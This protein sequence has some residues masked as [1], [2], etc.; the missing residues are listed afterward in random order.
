MSRFW[1]FLPFLALLCCASSADTG[2]ACH[3]GVCFPFD[4]SVYQLGEIEDNGYDYSFTLTERKHP[5]NAATFH[6]IL[7]PSFR[8]EAGI[9]GLDERMEEDLVGFYP[10]EDP[11][12]RFDGAFPFMGTHSYDPGYPDACGRYISYSGFRGEGKVYGRAAMCFVRD[13]YTRMYTECSNEASADAFLQLF[14]D[15]WYPEEIIDNGEDDLQDAGS[16]DFDFD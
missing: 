5:E 16:P 9:V 2:T 15:A 3:N 1:A 11:D 8:A 4:A 10:Q 12:F 7:D 13:F 14:R 6:I